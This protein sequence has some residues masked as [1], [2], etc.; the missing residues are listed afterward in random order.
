MSTVLF[1]DSRKIANQ[2][3]KEVHPPKIYNQKI[4][5]GILLSEVITSEIA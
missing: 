1:L 2:K 5:R 3:K 4:I